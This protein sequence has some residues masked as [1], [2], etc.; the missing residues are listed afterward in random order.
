[1]GEKFSVDIEKLAGFGGGVEDLAGYLGKVQGL[2]DGEAGPKDG[3][4][5]L[6]SQLKGPFESTKT[7]TSQR[8]DQRQVAMYMTGNELI[9]L[10]NTYKE[11]ENKTGDRIR[12]AASPLPGHDSRRD[13]DATT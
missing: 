6:M 4:E 12:A 10:A 13:G 1:M 2:V 3:W 9:S 11:Q 7:K 8:Y 5:G